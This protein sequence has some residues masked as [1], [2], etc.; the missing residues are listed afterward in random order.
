MGAERYGN[1]RGGPGRGADR[2]GGRRRGPGLV[3]LVCAALFLTGC[4]SM[5]SGGEVHRID[6]SPRAD[7]DSQVRVF[8]VPPS[9]G[10][11]PTQIVRGFLEATTSD[12]A[13]FSTARMYLTERARERWKPFAMT[14]VLQDGPNPRRQRPRGDPDE[15]GLIVEVT[16]RKVATVD[17]N[18]A[19]TPTDAD[20]QKSVHLVREDG[21]WRIDAP[22]EGLLLGKSDFE[23]IYR[24]VDKYYFAEPQVESKG[25]RKHV[26][27][28]DPVYL[29]KRIDPVTTTV[30]SLLRGPT[31]WL[32]PVASTAF[33]TGT[34]LI[35]NSLALDDSNGLR[36]RLNE[37]GSRV[38]AAQC[39]RMAAQ[40]MFTVQELAPAEVGRV[41]LLRSTGSRLCTLTSGQAEMF[42]PAGLRETSE[43]QYFIDAQQRMAALADVGTDTMLVDG[44]FGHGAVPLGSVGVDRSERMAAGVSADGRSLYVAQM[45][46]GAD[47]GPVRLQSAAQSADH[48]LTAPSWD[49]NGDLWVA[50]RDPARPRL[51]RLP[52]GTGKPQEVDVPS[53]GDAEIRSLRVASDGLRI[54][55]L[56]LRDGRQSLELGRVERVSGQ[57]EPSLT[58][59]DLHSVTPR[60]EHVEAASWAGASRLVVV[61][62]EPGGVQQL[63]YVE[64]DGSAANTPALPGINGVQAVAASED[65]DKPLIADSADGIVRLPVDANWRL[66]VNRGTA[67]VYPG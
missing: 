24:S 11:R 63:Q 16:G 40:V 48:G 44:P 62:R 6:A 30:R 60:M 34:R 28:S 9:R 37:R 57:A 31:D 4:A 65:P 1:R 64:T 32:E 33:P 53:L 38:G 61:G 29:R 26:L 45:K 41:E 39:T 27:V 12:E 17:R 46:K 20:Y 66:V 47:R 67:P 23:R 55:L 2:R 35:G 49:G 51:L 13:R 43:R 59:N 21:E 7:T 22:P 18:Q 56:V 10:E 54:A 19:Y 5:P 58:V 25:A 42:A 14:T 50:D 3:V 36:V 15:N 8:G 52:G